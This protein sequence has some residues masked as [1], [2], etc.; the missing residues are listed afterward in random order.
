[1]FPIGDH[2]LHQILLGGLVTATRSSMT[3]VPF[4]ILKYCRCM[5]C[6][7]SGLRT[8]YHSKAMYVEEQP[9]QGAYLGGR[10]SLFGRK[11]Y[12]RLETS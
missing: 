7:R 10:L 2:C 11:R 6:A 4:D 1:M 3:L 8:T 5:Y 9:V 12:F